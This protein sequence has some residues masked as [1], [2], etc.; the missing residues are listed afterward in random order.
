MAWVGGEVWNTWQEVLFPVLERT[1]D[2]ASAR[3]SWDP[4]GEFLG[5][6]AGR[7]YV[8]VFNLLSLEVPY[9]TLSFTGDGVEGRGAGRSTR[10][11]EIDGACA[12]KKKSE[13]TR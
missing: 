2:G 4:R 12:V 8:T 7:L 3:G 5:A 10:G 13:T 9:R 1:Q 11:R 6:Y